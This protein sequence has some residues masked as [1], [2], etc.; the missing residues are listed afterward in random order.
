M[1]SER[2]APPPAAGS[3]GGLPARAE[4][5]AMAVECGLDEELLEDMLEAYE[6][7]QRPY[8]DAC[9]PQMAIN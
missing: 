7:S 6:E 5:L 1:E 9:C 2:R 4:L 3:G 8:W